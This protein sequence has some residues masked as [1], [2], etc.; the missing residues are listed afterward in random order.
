VTPFVPFSS[1]GEVN[2]TPGLAGNRTRGSDA[3]RSEVTMG[4]FRITIARLLLIIVYFGVGFAAMRSP[5]WIWAST[6]FS[7]VTTSLAAATLTALYRPGARRA[8][9]T[10]FAFC[11]WLYLGLSS[12]PW[13]GSGMSPLIITSALMDLLYPKIGDVSGMRGA[14]ATTESIWEYWSEPPRGAIPFN[15][16]IPEPYRVICHSLLTPIAALLGGLL[17][18]WLHRTGDDL[19]T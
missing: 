10:G 1:S 11:G 9:W 12:Y 5:S 4:R 18:R 2:M 13:S 19:K 16:A 17:A 8:F 3:S 6:L 14:A 7:L 15:W